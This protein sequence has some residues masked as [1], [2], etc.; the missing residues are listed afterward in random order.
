MTYRLEGFTRRFSEMMQSGLGRAG[1]FLNALKNGV[2]EQ[3]TVLFE[4]APR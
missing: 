4:H 3:L 2:R 1:G